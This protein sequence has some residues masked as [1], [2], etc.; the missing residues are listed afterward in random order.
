MPELNA[1]YW[2]NRY[3]EHSTGWD[4]GVVS[5]P[6]KE[7]IDQL[8][9][10]SIRILIP[11]CGN[12]YEAAYLMEKGFTDI[13][14]ID[15]SH[16]LVSTLQNKFPSE[17]YPAIRILSGDFFLLDNPYDLILE[18]TFF[19]ALHP[20]MREEYAQKMKE[21]LTENGKLTGVLFNRSFEGGPPFGGHEEEYRTLFEKYF[22]IDIMEPCYNSIAPRAGA[23]LFISLSKKTV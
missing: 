21:L 17:N 3:E 9:D 1:G 20:S 18:Q 19:C 6:L 23:E 5:P 4:L 12:A 8:S 14:L 10:K 22:S 16:I 2:N 13:T 11:G 15:I 7:Y